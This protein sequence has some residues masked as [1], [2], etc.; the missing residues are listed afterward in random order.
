MKIGLWVGPH[1]IPPWDFRH[2]TPTRLC[3]DKADRRIECS[4][5]YRGLVR[6][7]R[8]SHIYQWPGCPYSDSIGENN[9]VQFQTPLRRKLPGSERPG[10]VRDEAIERDQRR[11]TTSSAS[12]LKATT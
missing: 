5:A 4:A 7:N 2:G 11:S 12:G 1:P 10:T 6:G 8:R 3:F 9:R